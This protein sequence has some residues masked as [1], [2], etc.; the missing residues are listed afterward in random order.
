MGVREV[1]LVVVVFEGVGE[2]E[3]LI[4]SLEIG[5][6]VLILLV[7]VLEV[8][9]VLSSSSP[10]LLHLPVLLAGTSGLP[11]LLNPLLP[12]LRINKHLHS[13]VIQRLS[14]DHIEHVELHSHSLF[15]VANS[16]EEPL[17]G[18]GLLS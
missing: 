1:H 7:I 6:L 13:L 12:L 11:L 9:D 10:S 3:S 5:K 17:G 8:A 16:E 15:D 14:L 2:R 4:A 18:C